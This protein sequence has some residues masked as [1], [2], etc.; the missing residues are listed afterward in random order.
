MKRVFDIHAHIYPDAI[1]SHAVRAISEAYDGVPIQNDGR[2]DTLISKLDEAEIRAAAIHSVATTPHHAESINR[3]I[4]GVA[5]AHPRRFVPFASL[6]PDMPDL[7]A[8]V[9]DVVEKGFAGVKLHPECQRFLVDEPRA[10]RL[11]GLLAGRLPVLMHCG[12]MHLDNSAPERVLRML[13]KVPDLTLICAHLGGWTSWEKSSRALIGSG[14]YADCSSSLFA[15]DGETAVRILRGYGVDH[16]FFGSD[17]PA[18]TPGEELER[19]FRLPLDGD[20]REQILWDNAKRMF[21]N[22]LPLADGGQT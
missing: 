12:D 5:Q 10:I 14:V 2:L 19:F 6:H 1:A 3:Y 13:D 15:L 21:A 8:A 9:E 11:L 7:E 17:Y 18:W 22:A 4:L 16:V 20:E